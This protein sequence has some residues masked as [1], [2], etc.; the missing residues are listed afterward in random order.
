MLAL[1][2]TARAS[3]LSL[4]L[5]SPFFPRFFLPLTLARSALRSFA[6]CAFYSLFIRPASLSPAISISRRVR[7]RR[8]MLARAVGRSVREREVQ[9]AV[10]GA[11]A[12]AA[13]K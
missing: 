10:S 11:V 5:L 6:I 3:S 9:R 12:G 4:S 8:R 1:G 7:I 2:W 13:C